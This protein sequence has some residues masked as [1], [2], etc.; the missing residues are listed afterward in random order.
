LDVVCN[1][2]QWD[3]VF[4]GDKTNPTGV[5]VYYK[6]KKYGLSLIAMPPLT[7]YLGIW[8]QYPPQQLKKERKIAFELDVSKALIEKLPSFSYF[9]IQL[10]PQIQ[11]FLSFKWKGFKQ[12]SKFTYLIDTSKS[13][14]EL[15]DQLKDKTRN[16]I[17]KAQN[18]LHAFAVDRI[19]EFDLLNKETF[20]RQGLPLPYDGNLIDHL[21]QSLYPKNRCSVLLAKDADKEICAGLFLVKDQSKV[22][23]IA[24][25]SNEKA[26]KNGAVS[27]LIWQAIIN[28]K[29]EGLN[30]DFEGS[31]MQN[32]EPFFRSFGGDQISYNQILKTSNR[33]TDALLA[34]TKR[35]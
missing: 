13:E 18:T 29:E 10:L 9:N 35:V 11:N 6:K 2:G 5:L 22:Y 33:F 3:V 4:C 25:G 14:E 20:R 19:D 17:R 12:T 30:F 34:F 21:F 31:V 15:W 28:A 26:R 27:M 23:C 1:K 16:T 7:P 32:I 24:I 8:Y